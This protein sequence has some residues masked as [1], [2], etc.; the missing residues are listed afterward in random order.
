MDKTRPF[1]LI[2]T[3]L[4]IAVENYTLEELRAELATPQFALLRSRLAY[5]SGGA[6]PL[7]NPIP[8][9]DKT[10]FSTFGNKVYFNGQEFRTIGFN[11]REAIGYGDIMQ[12]ATPALLRRQLEIVKYIGGKTVR[13]Y[14]AHLN[15]TASQAAARTEAFLNLL[16]E[17][18]LYGIV[19]LDEGA[20]S[21]FRIRK[22]DKNY[23]GRLTH[24]FYGGGYRDE[25][26]PYI[27]EVVGRVGSHPNIFCF[28]IMNE[29]TTPHPPDPTIPQME[30]MLNWMGAAVAVIRELAPTKLASNGFI[31]AWEMGANNAYSGFNFAQKSHKLVDLASFHTYQGQRNLPFG[32]TEPNIVREVQLQGIPMYIGE[33]GLE[34]G[35]NDW[36]WLWRFANNPVIK[37]RCFMLVQWALMGHE[38]PI[39]E[40]RQNFDIGTGDRVGMVQTYAKGMPGLYWTEYVNTY[41]MLLQGAYK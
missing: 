15:L 12:Y 35:L 9:S 3:I 24:N 32:D 14:A 28:E 37:D 6:A 22:A 30:A 19:V 26:I 25:Y 2:E 21:D 40:L 7:P 10:P 13:F 11:L 38:G 23:Q 29:P 18:G 41:R 34:P 16:K 20:G 33:I 39:E 31:S 4:N 8:V 17:Y 27:R 36:G 5:L 1:K